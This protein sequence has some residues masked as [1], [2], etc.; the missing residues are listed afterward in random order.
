MNA[1]T[2]Q[3]IRGAIGAL[4]I[5]SA[6][7]WL[8]KIVFLSIRADQVTM[9]LI[10]A[11][12]PSVVCCVFSSWIGISYLRPRI[13]NWL[14]IVA[15]VGVVFIILFGVLAAVAPLVTGAAYWGR[16]L[17]SVLREALGIML[18]LL[19]LAGIIV[20]FVSRSKEPNQQPQ[21]NALDLT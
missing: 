20:V 12:V 2:L 14:Q 9:R 15:I 1:D 6:I 18:R 16:D 17:V 21:R 4:L 3:R 5:Y 8:S 10:E 13:P 11:V 7:D 19:I